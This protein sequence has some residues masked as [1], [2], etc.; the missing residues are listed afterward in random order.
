MKELE[1]V[2]IVEHEYVVL[3]HDL[4]KYGLKCGDVGVVVHIYQDGKAYE[5]EFTHEVLTLEAVD[6]RPKREQETLHV[7]ELEAA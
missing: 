7:R 1:K 3:T 2:K 4:E 5:V 6:V